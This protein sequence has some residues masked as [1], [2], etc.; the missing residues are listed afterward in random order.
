MKMG[1]LDKGRLRSDS[2]ADFQGLGVSGFCKGLWCRKCEWEAGLIQSTC[3]LACFGSSWEVQLV[4][5]ACPDNPKPHAQA[6]RNCAP[7]PELR[8]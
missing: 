1:L 5:E 8:T 3:C 2:L 7:N 6:A 4:S